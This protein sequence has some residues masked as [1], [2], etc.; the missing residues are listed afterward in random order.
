MVALIR[1]VELVSRVGKKWSY[2]WCL[3]EVKANSNGCGVNREETVKRIPGILARAPGETTTI[4][5]SIMS[6]FCGQNR[7]RAG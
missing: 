5:H 1:V 3:F 4:I 2:P 7:F 6:L